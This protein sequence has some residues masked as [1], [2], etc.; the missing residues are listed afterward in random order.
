MSKSV[1]VEED[2][3]RMIRTNPKVAMALLYHDLQVEDC[4]RLLPAAMEEIALKSDS[5]IEEALGQARTKTELKLSWELVV[6]ARLK[7]SAVS[8]ASLA[9][10]AP[11]MAGIVSHFAKDALAQYGVDVIAPLFANGLP[12]SWMAAGLREAD[13][14]G[15][16]PVFEAL[17][18]SLGGNWTA[19]QALEFLSHLPKSAGDAR[20]V[21]ERLIS[22]SG[23]RQGTQAE[24]RAAAK[25]LIK[26]NPE[27]LG[28]FL[29]LLPE[30]Y[31]KRS[32]FT[33]VAE[34]N[35]D[36]EVLAAANIPLESASAIAAPVEQ[37]ATMKVMRAKD[38]GEGAL[39]WALDIADV[40][41]RDTALH[42]VLSQSGLVYGPLQPL[43]LMARAEKTANT[44]EAMD[45]AVRQVLTQLNGRQLTP[46]EITELRRMAAEGNGALQ[47]ALTR[48]NA[49][50]ILEK[51]EE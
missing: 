35:P 31:L 32:L 43:K 48:A 44:E 18:K 9:K 39:K 20:Q 37:A 25:E 14:P 2:L 24:Y 10:N 27:H 47:A 40:S 38:G 30:G 7:A 12:F 21:M 19:G 41:E 36:K 46:D 16:M 26:G 17:D 34:T 51:I 28:S 29:S 5:V 33:A 3:R 22:G 6:A 42:M 50:V 49:T 45:G 4:M 8:A 1:P 15:A 23:C 11:P 13:L